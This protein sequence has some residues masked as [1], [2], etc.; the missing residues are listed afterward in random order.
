[1]VLVI[2]TVASSISTQNPI[3]VLKHYFESRGFKT[4]TIIPP[5]LH[6]RVKLENNRFYIKEENV[7]D[8]NHRIDEIHTGFGLPVLSTHHIS[9]CGWSGVVDAEYNG[10][11]GYG[12]V[13]LIKKHLNPPTNIYTHAHENGH[14]LWYIGKQEKIYRKFKHPDYVRLKISTND[15]FAELCGWLAIKMAGYDPDQCNI[16]SRGKHDKKTINK[17]KELVRDEFH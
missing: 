9:C 8:I 12:Y 13:V 1:M 4:G 6:L 15:E 11:K 2:F 17:I 16:Q 3:K 10:Q 14:F 5:Y 7:N